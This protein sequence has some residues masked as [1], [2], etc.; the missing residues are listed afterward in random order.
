MGS[1]DDARRRA[2]DQLVPG[3]DGKAVGVDELSKADAKSVLS[4]AAEVSPDRPARHF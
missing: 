1:P 4:N 3:V 2:G